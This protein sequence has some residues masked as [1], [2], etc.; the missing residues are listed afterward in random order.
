MKKSSTRYTNWIEGLLAAIVFLGT[1]WGIH[2]M[3]KAEGI[4][5]YMAFT[6]GGE[7]QIFDLLVDFCAA[8]A[9]FLMVFLPC[10]ILRHRGVGP[11]FRLMT[12]FTAFMPTLSMS[13]L[14]HLF[15]EGGRRSDPEL[16]LS[17][18]GTLLPFACLLLFGVSCFEKPWKKWY[19]VLGLTAL[20]L[21]IGALWETESFGFLLV[22]VL[23]LVCFDAWERLLLLMP[24]MQ[25]FSGGRGFIVG[26]DRIVEWVLFGGLWLRAVYCILRMW[27]I[28]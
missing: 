21:G 16:L 9:V 27:S 15:D 28:Y 17:V 13:Y 20:I 14:I 4:G 2:Q 24:R 5:L 8:L 22:Y 19:G 7:R 1:A 10:V 12:C 6:I 23:L 25:T 18:P 3:Q 26:A 11:F